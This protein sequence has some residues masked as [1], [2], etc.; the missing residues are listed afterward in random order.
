[1][2]DQ[3]DTNEYIKDKFLKLPKE[4]QVA[5]TAPDL[6][7]K[8]RSIGDK[9]KLLL[10]KQGD[11][12]RQILI[13][14][15]GLIPSSEF[16][17][18]VS[19]VLGISEET[20][21]SIAADV[22]EQIFNPI[23]THLREWEEQSEKNVATESSSTTES[24]TSDFQKIGG[25]TVEPQPASM[26]SSTLKESDME[27]RPAILNSIEN[28]EPAPRSTVPFGAAQTE[29]LADHLLTTPVVIPPQK[30]VQNLEQNTT[31]KSAV[32]QIP[33]ANDPYRELPN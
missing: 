26:Q 3:L 23:R 19:E 20:A 2:T 18:S 24:N 15:L 25:F 10:D 8:M 22:N 12:Q 9:Y 21:N 16:V 32:R 28:P 6:M 13:V 33:L 11:L 17:S 27:S 7:L 1:M 30:I 31:T 4:V 29:P 5:I 14:M